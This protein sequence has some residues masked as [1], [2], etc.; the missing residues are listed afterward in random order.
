MTA[1]DLAD[2]F[3][4]LYSE[5]NTELMHDVSFEQLLYSNNHPLYINARLNLSQCKISFTTPPASDATLLLYVFYGTRTEEYYE[6]PRR[7]VTT[8]FPLAANEEMTLQ[9]VINTY[10]HALPGKICGVMCWD[11]E[12]NPAY[13]T[14]RDYTLTYVMANIH[15][16]MARPD[17]NGG[18]ADASQAALFLLNDLDI[19]FD[20]SHIRNAT[21][22]PN[23]QKIT[24]LYN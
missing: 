19:D 14:L 4:S 8:E 9:D 24:F 15:T 5:D 10:V 2:C 7:S 23:T 16:A 22:T 20:Y 21:A 1:S 3:V 17:M 18:A 13:L 12:N 11:A 6:L